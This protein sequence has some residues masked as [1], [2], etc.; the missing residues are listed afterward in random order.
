VGKLLILDAAGPDDLMPWIWAIVLSTS[1]LAIV[2]FGRAGSI[3]FWKSAALPAEPCGEGAKAGALP[4]VA[5][6]AMLAGLVALTVLAGPAMLFFEATADQ[7]MDGRD[8]IGAVLGPETV[9]RA[10]EP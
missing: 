3:L 2:G 10:G 1:L 6:G 5:A 4:T 9:A 7:L 8:Y